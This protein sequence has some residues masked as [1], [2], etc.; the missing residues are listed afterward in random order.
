[1]DLLFD[2]TKWNFLDEKHIVSNKD[3]IPPKGRANPLTGYVDFIPVT[4]DFRD[5]YN[6]FAVISGNPSKPR[7]IQYQINLENGNAETFR[8]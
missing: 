8:R 7:P 1:M 6:V 3:A 5:S 2:H 4:V